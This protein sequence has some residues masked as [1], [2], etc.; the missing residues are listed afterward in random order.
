MVKVE[1]RSFGAIEQTLV[2][3]VWPAPISRAKSRVRALCFCSGFQTPSV[4]GSPRGAVD[5]P[6]VFGEGQGVP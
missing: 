2:W 1:G 3:S 6:R 4:S 5:G